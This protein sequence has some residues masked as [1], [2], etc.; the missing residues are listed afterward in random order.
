MPTAAS[1]TDS[2][3]ATLLNAF[4]NDENVS[5]L[6]GN[7]QCNQP[8]GEIINNATKTVYPRVGKMDRDGQIMTDGTVVTMTPR[9]IKTQKTQNKASQ[10]QELMVAAE[11]A[12]G[13]KRSAQQPSSAKKIKETR[14]PAGTTIAGGDKPG[15]AESKSQVRSRGHRH[16]A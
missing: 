10:H 12:N 5:A 8:T 1:Q 2:V 15:K 4:L 7:K 13:T 6:M 16:S 11:K 9:I 14:K 3:A